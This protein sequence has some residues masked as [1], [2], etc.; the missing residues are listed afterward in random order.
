MVGEYAA[1][2]GWVRWFWEGGVRS[3]SYGRIAETRSQAGRTHPGQTHLVTHLPSRTT[4]PVHASETTCSSARSRVKNVEA[5][6]QSGAT[7]VPGE[8]E[9]ASSRGVPAAGTLLGM[10]ER[11]PARN[12]AAR[13]KLLAW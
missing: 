9:G 8:E 3:Q 2:G 10:A 7:F 13:A 5:L 1:G 6:L 11:A 12:A 4:L